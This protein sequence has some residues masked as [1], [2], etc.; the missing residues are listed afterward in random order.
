[1]DAAKWLRLQW[2][3]VLAWVLVAAGAVA[4]IIGWVGVSGTSY[5]AE[6]LPYIISGGIG[7]IF[8][9]GVGATLWLSADLRD[10]WRKLDRIEEAL[11]QRDLRP[12]HA[13]AD[14]I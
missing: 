3:R 1:V 5:S 10:E 12:V 14:T 8:L 4:L 6:Q 9:L 13:E 2:D 11:Q 7:G